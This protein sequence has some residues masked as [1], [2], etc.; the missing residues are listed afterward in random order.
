MAANT[1]SIIGRTA[2]VRGRLTGEGDLEVQGFVEGEISVGGD[3]TVDAHGLVGASIRG[4]RLVVRGAVKG[5][6]LGEEAISLEDGARVVGD[7]RAPRVAIA[8]ERS[9]AAYV[10]TGEGM[11]G[12]GAAGRPRPARA[13]LLPWRSGRPVAA[14]VP[15]R[16]LPSPPPRRR[17][18]KRR[19]RGRGAGARAEPAAPAARDEPARPP[20][21]RPRR[22]AA[23]RRATP[24]PNGTAVR[25]PRWS[26]RS[27]KAKGQMRRRALVT[28]PPGCLVVPFRARALARAAARAL[29]RAKARDLASGGER[30]LHRLQAGGPHGGGARA[31]GR[32]V[33][34]RDRR[35]APCVA[36]AGV[37]LGGCPSRARSR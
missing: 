27:K 4:R 1:T 15:R 23:R 9:C 14:P 10:E 32:A 25:R 8:P 11:T 31:G 19:A 21:R 17:R 26:P 29:V 37:E 24:S 12:A 3:V 7:V 36:V 35:A 22:H 28:S 20:R 34:R 18:S 6:L 33:V 16:P 5:D 13:R 30:L 2:R